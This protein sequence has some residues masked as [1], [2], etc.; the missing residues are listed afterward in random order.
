MKSMVKKQHDT[1]LEKVIGMVQGIAVKLYYT[2]TI[3]YLLRGPQN[4]PRYDPSAV[5]IGDNKIVRFGLDLPYIFA[6]GDYNGH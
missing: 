3:Q 2:D 5:V 6:D 4:R 1:N